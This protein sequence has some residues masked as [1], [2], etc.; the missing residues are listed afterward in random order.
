MLLSLPPAWPWDSL[1]SGVQQSGAGQ[2]CSIYRERSLV[3]AS[4]L[5]SLSCA[6]GGKYESV[7]SGDH[8]AALRCISLQLSVPPPG[9]SN[10]GKT[11]SLKASESP[12]TS[13]LT[14]HTAMG[15]KILQPTVTVEMIYPAYKSHF[16][17]RACCT[18]V[19]TV[20]GV[21]LL[22]SWRGMFC[23]FCFTCQEAR[24]RVW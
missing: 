4:S 13:T 2:D 23:L 19:S 18:A 11:V 7:V 15:I 21:F 10:R 12:T 8:P 17:C 1:Q 22:L 24:E 14:V 9:T 6:S 5:F 16:L 20:S 3:I